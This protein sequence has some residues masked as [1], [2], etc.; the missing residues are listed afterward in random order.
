MTAEELK[1]IADK[2]GEETALKIKTSISEAEKAINEQ[3]AE[4]MKGYMPIS[5]FEAFKK[6]QLEPVNAALAKIDEVMTKQGNAIKGVLD[7]A[8]PNT[9]TIENFIEENVEQ[10]KAARRDG[11]V[12]EFSAQQLKDAGIN[13]IASAIPTASP[14]APGIS[15]QPLQLFDI[16][17]NPN[18]ITS[19]VNLGSTNMSR[20]AWANELEILGVP[21]LTAE[22]ATKPIT[23]HTFKIETSNAKKIAGYIEMTEEFDT[24]LPQ[25]ST[26]VRRMLQNDVV[27]AWD[28]AIQVDVIAAARPFN[29]TQLNAT[30]QAANYWDALLAEVGQ[31]GYYNFI[32]NTV[33]IN[34]LTMV[35]LN[36]EK[37][38]QNQY[39]LPPFRDMI[40]GMINYANKIATGYGL[41]GD[42]QQYNVDIYKD[43]SL[44]VGWINDDFIKNQFAVVGEVRYHSY[45]SDVRRNAI[46]YDSLATIDGIITEA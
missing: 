2:V 30:I 3:H 4:V 10:F 12:I 1:A 38:T 7:K 9:K 34:Y 32:P 26:A 37:N 23:Q 8:A 28:D 40:D 20:M 36:T 18:Y 39:L 45:I 11:K 31:V 13:T 16:A 41:V 24:D 5:E 46:V 29:I 15:G 17:R 44:R 43:F 35:I 22:G 33:A 27:R 25:F 42:L 21:A 19:K 14:Y 6:D